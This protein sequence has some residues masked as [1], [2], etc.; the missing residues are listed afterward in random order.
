MP[1][2]HSPQTHS[3]DGATTFIVVRHGETH[4]NIAGR[5]QGHLDSRLTPVGLAQA[6]AL[7]ARL[8]AEP[9]H[10]LYS[11]DLGRARET[12]EPIAAATGLAP[13]FDARLRERTYGVFESFTWNEIEARFPA[14]FVRLASR[15]P[16][17]CVPGGESP[18]GFRERLLAAFAA[19]ADAHRG[20]RL[21]VVTH[22]G[23]LGML[24]RVARDLP[25]DAPRAYQLPNAGINRFAWRGGRLELE[26]WADVAHLE[27]AREAGVDT[28]DN[29]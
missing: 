9:L 22:G 15:D 21:A 19:L 26:A 1:L 25:L 24:Y 10:A 6:A 12:A 5:L 29:V 3:A 27:V 7:G 28:R 23:V 2:P 20:E 4:W 16:T 14:E 13:K 11:S 8:A 17:Y 18:I